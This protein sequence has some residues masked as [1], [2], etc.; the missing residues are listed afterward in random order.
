MSET[1]PAKIAVRFTEVWLPYAPGEI[2]HFAPSMAEGLIRAKVAVPVEGAKPE[3]PALVPEGTGDG[4][5]ADAGVAGAGATGAAGGD[6]GATGSTGAT[7]ADPGTDDKAK[8]A[9]GK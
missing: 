7:G 4:K 9:K 5:M 1:K 8:G 6:T 2:A 3:E